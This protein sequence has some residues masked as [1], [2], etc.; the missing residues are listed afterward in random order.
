MKKVYA[1]EVKDYIINFINNPIDKNSYEDDPYVSSKKI[2][3]ILNGTDDEFDYLS[4]PATND[5]SAPFYR[6][7]V[8]Y[9]FKLNEDKTK[10]KSLLAHYYMG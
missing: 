4:F 2:E 10:V 6:N 5:V 3:R 9:K 7:T 1:K 8:G